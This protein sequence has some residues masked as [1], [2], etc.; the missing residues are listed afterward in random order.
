MKILYILLC[1]LFLV[2]CN[3]EKTSSVTLPL[4]GDVIFSD[5]EVT[6]TG[7]LSYNEGEMIFSPD[8]P[9]GYK[10]TVTD[11]GGII[12]YNGIVFYENVIPSSRFLPLFEMLEGIKDDGV[13]ITKKPLTIEKEN[14][15]LT[16]KDTK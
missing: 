1:V 5:G 13:K 11:N 8:T 3:A 2:S 15:K 7:G 9:K 10:V 16:F 12:E 14:L 4:K 6:V